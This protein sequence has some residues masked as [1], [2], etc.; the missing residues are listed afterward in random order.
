ML[1]MVINAFITVRHGDFLH[2]RNLKP[3]FNAQNSH[4]ITTEVLQ[5]IYKHDQTDTELN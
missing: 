5:T 2:F 3:F 4:P 1:F